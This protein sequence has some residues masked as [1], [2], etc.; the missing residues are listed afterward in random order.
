MYALFALDFTLVFGCTERDQLLVLLGV[1]RRTQLG[2]A[3]RTI[4]DSPE[5]AY[6][7]GINIEGLFYLTSFAAAALGGAAG[8]MIAGLFLRFVEVLT[9]TYLSSDFR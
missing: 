7:L 4:A 1:M 8:A 2:R 9:L 3:L 6:L 5:V